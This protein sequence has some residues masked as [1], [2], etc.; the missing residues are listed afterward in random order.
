MLTSYKQPWWPHGAV[1][2]SLPPSILELENVHAA[3]R[4]GPLGR[5]VWRVVARGWCSLYQ[6]FRA[7]ALLPLVLTAVRYFMLLVAVES[8]APFDK[9]VANGSGRAGR[10]SFRA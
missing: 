7:G 9:R 2:A 3:M 6:A 10:Y 1:W 8:V 4:F 5:R